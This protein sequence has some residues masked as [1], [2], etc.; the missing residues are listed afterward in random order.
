MDSDVLKW[1]F[2]LITAIVAAFL[3]STLALRKTK[4]ERRWQA[5]YDAYQKILAAVESMRYWAEESY[6]S[7][8]L[9]PSVSSEKLS[10]LR[11]GYHEAK[12][13]LWSY[14]H[15]GELIVCI[16]SRELLEDLL[17]EIAREEF[18]FEDDSIDD[19]EFPAALA[20]HCDQIRTA[21]TKALPKLLELAKADI[22]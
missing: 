11:D 6:A 10:E 17:V 2:S 5:K 1:L 13:E 18:R 4:T 21:I 16:A 8:L 9:L 15:I 20:H 7:N 19:S 14:V 22:G 3:G 12:R